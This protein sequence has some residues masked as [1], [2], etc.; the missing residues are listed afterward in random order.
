MLNV[1]LK[2]AGK[3]PLQCHGIRIGSTLEY[4]LHNIPFDVVKIKGRWVS[5]SFLLYLHRHAQI[6]TPYMQAQP[7]L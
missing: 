3:S 4:Q 5:D 7:I 2:A 1:T 6:L